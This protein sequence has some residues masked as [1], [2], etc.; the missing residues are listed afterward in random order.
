[1]G[2]S[3]SIWVAR[4]LQMNTSDDFVPLFGTGDRY[5]QE[6]EEERVASKPRERQLGESDI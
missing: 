4:I 1:M 6:G 2:P 3:R 5:L